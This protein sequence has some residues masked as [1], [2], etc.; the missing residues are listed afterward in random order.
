[1]P[2]EFLK[3]IVAREAHATPNEAISF[4]V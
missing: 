2:Q 4:Y 1:M 3:F